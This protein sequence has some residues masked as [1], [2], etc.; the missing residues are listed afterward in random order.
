MVKKGNGRFSA[1]PNAQFIR[2]QNNDFE[3][4]KGCIKKWIPAHI[5][6]SVNIVQEFCGVH[7]YNGKTNVVSIFQIGK[8]R[9][10]SLP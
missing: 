10:L 1:M 9:Q 6:H 3:G 8:R 4:I 2:G 7:L 5:E